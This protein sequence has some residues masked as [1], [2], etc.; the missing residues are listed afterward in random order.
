MA[1]AGLIMVP[2]GV[3]ANIST[4]PGV[5][6]YAKVMAHSDGGRVVGTGI[7]VWYGTMQTTIHGADR[8]TIQGMPWYST[9]HAA[10]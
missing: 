5:S 3:P 2:C 4:V 6:M 1:D 10:P 7:V 9:I 8:S